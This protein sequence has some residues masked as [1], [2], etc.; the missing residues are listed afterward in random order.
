M[1]TFLLVLE[2][3]VCILLIITVLLQSGNKG[4][5]GIFSGASEQLSGN[6]STGAEAI[7]RKVTA[8]LGALFLILSIVLVTVY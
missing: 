8:V 2:V 1:K 6:Q 5:M 7:Y 4:G 3:V